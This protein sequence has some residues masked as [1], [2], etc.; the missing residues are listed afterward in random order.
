MSD[1]SDIASTLVFGKNTPDQLPALPLALVQ[2]ARAVVA[3]KMMGDQFLNAASGIKL[4]PEH[5]QL[6]IVPSILWAH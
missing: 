4:D 5:V 1:R 6:A 3:F 2:L